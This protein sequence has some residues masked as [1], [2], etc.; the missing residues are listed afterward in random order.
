MKYV[1]TDVMF[2]VVSGVPNVYVCVVSHEHG[3]NVYVA[4]SKEGAVAQLFEYVKEEWLSL[5]HNETMPDD[6]YEAIE[7]YFHEHDGESYDITQCD[8]FP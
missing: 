6:M 1:N 5:G 3:E 8:L 4:A 2:E 7:A